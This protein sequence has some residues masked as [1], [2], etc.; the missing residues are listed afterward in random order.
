[1][2]CRGPSGAGN[3]LST[4]VN[5]PVGRH[6]LQLIFSRKLFINPAISGTKLLILPAG[7]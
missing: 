2:V 6:R 4:T 7:S 1:M 5:K 3:S